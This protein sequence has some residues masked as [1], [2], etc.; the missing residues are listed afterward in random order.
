MATV[1]GGPSG[2]SHPAAEPLS[3]PGHQ[4]VP[5]LPW[6]AGGCGHSAGLFVPGPGQSDCQPQG[7]LQ[8]VNGGGMGWGA[9]LEMEGVYTY[10]VYVYIYE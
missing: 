3:D 8:G 4:H 5:P 6:R 10:I 1:S 7:L 9:V 2:G